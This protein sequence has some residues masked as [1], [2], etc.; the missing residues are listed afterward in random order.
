LLKAL[1]DRGQALC[2]T[3]LA[4]VAV[5][6]DQQVQVRKQASGASI[7]VD[8]A[9]L[10]AAQRVDEIARMLSGKVSD[11]SRRHAQE[12]LKGAA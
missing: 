1:A 10:N 7:E 9:L 5:C 11:Q 6:A 2:V 8:T 3:H 4:Q 12:M